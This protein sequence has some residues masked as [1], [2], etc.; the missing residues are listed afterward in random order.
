MLGEWMVVENARMR[1]TKSRSSHTGQAKTRALGL[2][3]WRGRR[4]KI[5]SGD[6]AIRRHPLAVPEEEVVDRRRR[7]GPLLH[8][9]VE[10]RLLV[11]AASAM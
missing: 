3:S 1:W 5:G 9:A 2:R 11:E 6:T 4:R 10:S 8:M 7:G